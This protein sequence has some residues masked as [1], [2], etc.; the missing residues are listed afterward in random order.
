MLILFR[1]S[2]LC[3]RLTVS[4]LSYLAGFVKGLFLDVCRLGLGAILA[5]DTLRTTSKLY[6]GMKDV[7]TTNRVKTT[8]EEHMDLLVGVAHMITLLFLK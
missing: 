7:K 5:A 8:L 1:F 6:I 2:R 4:T 3:Y